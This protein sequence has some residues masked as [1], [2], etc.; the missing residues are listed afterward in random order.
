[1]SII[2]RERKEVCREDAPGR[3]GKKGIRWMTALALLPVLVFCAATIRAYSTGSF[4]SVE[5][6][7]HYILQFGPFGPLFLTAFQAIQVILP[8][9]PAVPGCLAGTVL[10][11]PVAGFLWNY[12]G[13]SA[14]SFIAFLLARKFGVPLLRNLFPREKFE[15]WSSQAAKSRSYTVFLFLAIALPF[16]PDDFLCYFSGVTE[17]KPRTFLWIILLGK[18]WCI[19]AYSFGVTLLT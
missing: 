15:K 1:M 2:G 8:F 13:I 19:L 18:P 3:G 6:L 5:S 9:L 12:I 4:D 7:Q 14:G 17:M 16:F 10:F 11:G